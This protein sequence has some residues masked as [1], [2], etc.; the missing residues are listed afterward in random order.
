MNKI[1][2]KKQVKADIKSDLRS[3]KEREERLLRKLPLAALDERA[4]FL[5]LGKDMPSNATFNPYLCSYDGYRAYLSI[6]VDSLKEDSYL[7]A[8]LER[9]VERK[10]VVET[11]DY[12]SDYSM[13]RTFSIYL[14]HGGKLSV[15]AR[16]SADSKTCRKVQVGVEVKEIAKFELRCD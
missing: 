12:V 10:L 13:D 11:S 1:T 5:L 15:E 4:T 3:I 6:R 16:V 7:L 9:A 8:I 14:P 2:T